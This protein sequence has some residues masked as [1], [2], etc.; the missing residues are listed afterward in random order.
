MGT[1]PQTALHF[2]TDVVGRDAALLK[3]R[4]PS[5]EMTAG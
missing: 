1:A 2:M 5:G 4:V 3:S